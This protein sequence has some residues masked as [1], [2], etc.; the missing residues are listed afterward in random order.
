[1]NQPKVSIVVPLM[2]KFPLERVEMLLSKD[3][4]NFWDGILCRKYVC[5]DKRFKICGVTILKI[6]HRYPKFQMK[7]LGI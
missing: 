1:M 4:K 2:R 6:S 3:K 7:L 5:Y